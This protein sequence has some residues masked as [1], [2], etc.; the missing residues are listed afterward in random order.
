MTPTK[1]DVPTFDMLINPTLQ[2]LHKLGGS[3]AIQE[4]EDEIVANLQI[5]EAVAEIS[6]GRGA[7][8]K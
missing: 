1:D 5:P 3:A 6:H 2:A 7:K 8:L 4:L